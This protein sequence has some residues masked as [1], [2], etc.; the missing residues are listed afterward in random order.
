M[1]RFAPADSAAASHAGGAT[2]SNGHAAA[3]VGVAPY[4]GVVPA[5]AK[6]GQGVRPLPALGRDGP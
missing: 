1:R 6:F 3:G 4:Q 5:N 2:R